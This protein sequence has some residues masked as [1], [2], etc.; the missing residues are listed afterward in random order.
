MRRGNNAVVALDQYE[1]LYQ[2]L[3]LG[4]GQSHEEPRQHIWY[5]GRD[6]KAETHED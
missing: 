5:W 2:H 4:T 6:L 3:P 1:E